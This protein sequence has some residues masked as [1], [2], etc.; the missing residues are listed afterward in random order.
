ML[1]AGG[2][3]KAVVKLLFQARETKFGLF[4]F[5]SECLLSSC[6]CFHVR[7]ELEPARKVC[8]A[9]VSYVRTVGK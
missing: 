7:P 9:A 5:V 2:K 8:R 1:G 3:K 6:T 4:I